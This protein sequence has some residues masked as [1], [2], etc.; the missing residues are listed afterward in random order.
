MKREGILAGDLGSVI[1]P[2]TGAARLF[3]SSQGPLTKLA[4]NY[5]RIVES[6]SEGIWTLDLQG[7]VLYA[8]NRMAEILGY[9]VEEILGRPVFDF[10]PLEERSSIAVRLERRRGGLREQWEMKFLRK[11]GRIVWTL[12]NASPFLGE[13]GKVIAALG[14]FSDITLLKEEQERGRR[15]AVL[16]EQSQD[17]VVSA[18]LSG[19]ILYWNKSAERIFGYASAE[20]IFQNI[21]ALIPQDLL[22]EA[23]ETIRKVTAGNVVEPFE[24]VRIRKDGKLIQVSLLVSAI[25]DSEGAV[26]GMNAIVRDITAQQELEAKY[27]QVQRMEAIGLLAS[28]VAH[29]FNN[30]LGVILMSAESLQEE[31]R[32]HPESVAHLASIVQAS[33][34]AVGLTRQLLNFSRRKV[35]TTEMVELNALILETEQMLARVI[36]EDIR[37]ETELADDLWK[38][39][40]DAGQMDQLIMNLAVNSR[41][42]MPQ[43]GILKIKTSNRTLDKANTGQL[44]PGD[45]VAIEVTDSGMGIPP[46]VLTRI[47]EPFFTTKPKG[48]GTGLGL[49]TVFG[50]AKQS[51]GGVFVLSE[52]GKGTVFTVLLPR[53]TGNSEKPETP[54][55]ALN[56]VAGTETILFV[57]DEQT[58]REVTAMIL[59]RHGYRVLEASNGEEGIRLFQAADEKIDLIMTDVVMPGISGPDMVQS[60]RSKNRNTPVIV[61]VSGYSEDRLANIGDPES[62]AQW[63][64][65]PYTTESLL[66]K[67]RLFLDEKSETKGS[68]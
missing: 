25:R 21:S 66:T 44:P 48:K 13:D 11:D 3:K 7:K 30:L 26:A 18:D 17:A 64:E 14:M 60:L 54:S 28:G 35:I 33:E 45:Y 20:I 41:D 29:D 49:S 27:Q 47:F 53:F 61:F 38:I 5:R 15:L 2:S 6:A 62:R 52:A 46:E 19:K 58:L 16:V 68:A 9:S 59:R 8:N 32:A 57:E 42:A 39:R 50:I 34:R 36:G 55:R 51:G 12:A 63:L 23:V 37:L 56:Q 1:D 24:T 67:I 40:V 10:V 4:A 65:K 31:L 43:G 22:P